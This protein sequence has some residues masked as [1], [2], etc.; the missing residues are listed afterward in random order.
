METVGIATIKD[1]DGLSH[2]IEGVRSMN[3]LVKWELRREIM[4]F[5]A[6]KDHNSL[7]GI[8]NHLVNDILPDARS[9]YSKRTAPHLLG[10]VMY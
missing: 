7:A 10:S 4:H 8:E 6:G 3:E 2:G 1:V 5:V 9:K